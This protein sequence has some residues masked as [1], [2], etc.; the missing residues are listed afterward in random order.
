ML[1]CLFDS[2]APP[3]GQE[4]PAVSGPVLETYGQCECVRGGREE[5]N[6]GRAMWHRARRGQGRPLAGKEACVTRGPPAGTCSPLPTARR[7]V[8]LGAGPRVREGQEDLH[9]PLR[10]HTHT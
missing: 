8:L 10:A 3:G 5:M 9:L 6:G 1:S 7:P 2:T 4:G